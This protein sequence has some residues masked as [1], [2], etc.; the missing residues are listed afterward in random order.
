MLKVALFQKVMED[1]QFFQKCAENLPGFI[2]PV[3]G[4]DKM[5]II[6]YVANINNVLIKFKSELEQNLWFLYLKSKKLCTCKIIHNVPK[7][8]L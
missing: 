1:F 4:D 2:I 7:I 8:H 5:L 6:Q 3:H